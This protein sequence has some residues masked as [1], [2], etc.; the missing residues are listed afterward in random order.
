MSA[1]IDSRIDEVDRVVL[2]LPKDSERHNWDWYLAI[3]FDRSDTEP[4]QARLLAGGQNYLPFQHT[5]QIYSTLCS[6]R[7]QRC[8]D[9]Q[10]TIEAPTAALGRKVPGC[11]RACV[12]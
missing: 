9:Q 10:L 3:A 4:V 2:R 5:Y 1:E 6:D 12:R 11:S 7:A 8:V